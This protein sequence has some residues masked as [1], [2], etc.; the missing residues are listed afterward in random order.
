MDEIILYQF[1]DS[2]NCYK[3]RLY[4]NYL[5]QNYKIINLPRED[6]L[7][8]NEEFLKI[9]PLGK[10]P[11]LQVK[12]LVLTESMAI[13]FYL[14]ENYDINYKY[15][16]AL[17]KIE[18]LKWLSFEQSEIQWSIGRLRY[19]YKFSNSNKL[20]E[21]ADLKFNA[22]DALKVLDN[23]L[24][25]KKFILE[26]YSIADIS[27]FAYVGLS[28]EAGISLENYPNIHRWIKNF[29]EMK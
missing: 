10:V 22:M 12:E 17:E 6:A 11:V 21:T 15:F 9:S 2:G 3:I 29:P 26:K 27:L 24:K 25:N 4:L 8:K 16:T 7:R 14:F 18:I 13:L 23:H 28:N 19:I 5:H 20:I 1:P